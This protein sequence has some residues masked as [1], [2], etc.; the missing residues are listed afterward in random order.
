MQK[1]RAGYVGR[2]VKGGMKARQ[3]GR[4]SHKDEVRQEETGR[5][6]QAGWWMRPA[7]RKAR[8][9]EAD[10]KSGKRGEGVEQ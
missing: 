2:T 8:S 6:M 9:V 3:A 7:H 10:R 1:S 5:H 4:R